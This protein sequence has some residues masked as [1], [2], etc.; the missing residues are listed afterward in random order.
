MTN[1]TKPVY[2]IIAGF[3]ISFVVIIFVFLLIQTRNTVEISVSESATETQSK[4]RTSYKNR[5]DY[6]EPTEE[7]VFETTSQTSVDNVIRAKGLYRDKKDKVYDSDKNKYEVIDGN[8][9][10]VYQGNLHKIPV[11]E[12]EV[13]QPTEKPKKK[14]PKATEPPKAQSENNSSQNNYYSGSGN[15]S[16]SV[17]QSNNV[18]KPTSKPKPKPAPKNNVSM[19]YSS[20]TVPKGET[21]SLVLSGAT[22]GVSWS[23]DGYIVQILSNN[24]GHCVFTAKNCGSASVIANYKGN[25]YS[26]Y[27]TIS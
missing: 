10:I 16:V 9:F 1:K 15:S 26:C 21:F 20:L 23:A 13:V 3:L 4:P 7:T 14:K 12:L 2:L 5:I 24:G 8:V 18:V 19:N 6:T 25:S 27:V 11:E 22:G 17:N